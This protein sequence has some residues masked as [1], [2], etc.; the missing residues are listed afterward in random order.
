MTTDF[1]APNRLA[2]VA[3]LVQDVDRAV[4]FYRDT[5][6]LRFLFQP[7]PTLAFFD[8]GGTRLM[9]DRPTES[10]PGIGTSILY[11]AVDDINAAYAALLSRGA[12]FEDKPHIVAPL[13]DRDL[14][15]TFLRDSEGNLLAL[16]SEVR[17]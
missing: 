5:L 13:G 8:L 1:A 7:S 15:M 14:W 11:Y 12:R 3:I 6:G 4:R 2:Q 17:R 10:V 16:S 9:L